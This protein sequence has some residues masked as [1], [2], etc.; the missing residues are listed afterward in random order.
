MENVLSSLLL[1][2]GSLEPGKDGV[3]D[4]SRRLAAELQ[5]RGQRVYMVSLADKTVLEV[6]TGSQ[7]EQG[8]RIGV[9]R[10]PESLADENRIKLLAALLTKIQPSLV[11]LQFVPFSFHPKG[12]PFCLFYLLSKT[13]KPYSCHV[14]FHELWVGME[15]GA[16]VKMKLWG[17]V[18]RLLIGGFIK[19]LQPGL[20]H[21]HSTLYL[22]QL[23]L[24]G[25]HAKRLP[26]FGNI[27]VC[28]DNKRNSD[29]P[30]LTFVLFGMIHYGAPVYDF[31]AELHNLQAEFEKKIRL[32][33]VGKCGS[34]L[35]KWQKVAT[36][37]GLVIEIFGEQSPERVSRILS[38][39]NMGISTTPLWLSEK[40]GTVAAMR[41]HGLPVLCVARDW[42]PSGDFEF[43]LPAGLYNYEKG[44][45]VQS[46]Q[47]I[48][49]GSVGC[50]TVKSVA[51]VFIS[52][53]LNYY[54]G[55]S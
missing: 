5:R 38:T 28:P 29:E 14:M 9:T 33:F 18:Q 47:A 54:H 3:G 17:R 50:T 8:Q 24:L 20:I 44:E 53:V 13:L 36:E 52:D 11:S 7:V 45:L 51:D 30:K 41:E 39:A 10:I 25:F 1:I 35:S 55:N 34:E 26:L 19:R 6:V 21:S 22:Q 12:L 15:I 2:C 48:E 46:L 42:K 16:T 40:S 31:T 32:V 43:V 4:Y 37:A 23:E 49:N 27:P